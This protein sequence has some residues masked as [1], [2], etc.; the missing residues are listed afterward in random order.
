M[1][2]AKVLISFCVFVELCECVD[3]TIPTRSVSRKRRVHERN[4]RQIRLPPAPLD[5]VAV[6]LQ[7]KLDRV[8]K[9]NERTVNVLAVLDGKIDKINDKLLSEK[10]NGDETSSINARLIAWENKINELDH[11]LSTLINQ[12]EKREPLLLTITEND[13]P[14]T[15]ENMIGEMKKS[16]SL[17]EEKVE[18][19]LAQNSAKLED[20][21]QTIFEQ[22]SNASEPDEFSM[23]MQRNQRKERR[24]AGKQNLINE[25]LSVVKKKLKSDDEDDQTELPNNG[26]LTDMV[27][28]FENMKASAALSPEEKNKASG[29]STSRGITFPNVKNKPA[30]F[31]TTQMTETFGNKDIRVSFLSPTPRSEA[32]SDVNLTFV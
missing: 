22:R 14:S 8:E 21:K 16:L 13:E 29:N 4:E 17:I 23:Q 28:G 31:N 11:K 7:E 3:R 30:K 18:R 15:L 19:G 9:F 12:N 2:L 27:S 20:V 24:I 10:I 25:I 32:S 6:T 26:S 1:K 5:I